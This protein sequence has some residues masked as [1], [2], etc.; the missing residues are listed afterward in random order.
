MEWDEFTSFIVETGMHGAEAEH[1]TINQC[2]QC[3]RA[4]ATELF[5]IGQ[6]LLVS[7]N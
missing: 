3:I 2:V 4:W 6:E 7:D 5:E 1:Y